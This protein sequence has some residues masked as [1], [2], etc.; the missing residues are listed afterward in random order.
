MTDTS[1]TASGMKLQVRVFVPSPL[2]PVAAMPPMLAALPEVTGWENTIWIPSTCQGKRTLEAPVTKYDCEPNSTRNAVIVGASRATTV[3]ENWFDVTPV[4]L[5]EMFELPEATPEARPV[6][7]PMAA[8]DV[9]DE[10]HVTKL[11][12]SRFE[13][14]L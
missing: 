6:A 2:K 5:A 9:F 14:S 11:V 13:P 8:A 3:K 10:F 1:A 7:A 12:I 4:R